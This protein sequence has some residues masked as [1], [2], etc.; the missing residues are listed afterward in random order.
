MGVAVREELKGSAGEV[1]EQDS[2]PVHRAVA[3]DPKVP[4]FS[5]SP[6]LLLEIIMQA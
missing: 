4:S 1:G 5:P 3:N 2:G 6:S